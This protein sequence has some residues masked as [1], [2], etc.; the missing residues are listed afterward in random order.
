MKTERTQ[1]MIINKEDQY[2]N[3]KILVPDSQVYFEGNISNLVGHVF[4]KNSKKIPVEFNEDLFKKLKHA[5]QNSKNEKAIAL[6]Y[7]DLTKNK[8][9]KTEG[10]LEWQI[11]KEEKGTLKPAGCYIASNEPEN[12]YIKTAPRCGVNTKYVDPL[13]D[14]W[15]RQLR[16]PVIIV[17]DVL[18]QPDVKM[19]KKRHYQTNITS[20]QDGYPLKRQ[21]ID[22]LPYIFQCYLQKQNT[23]CI[24]YLNNLVK[25]LFDQSSPLKFAFYG[26]QF[27]FSVLMYFEHLQTKLTYDLKQCKTLAKQI[28]IYNKYYRKATLYDFNRFLQT[29]LMERIE[30]K[31]VENL[32][33]FWKIEINK[34]IDNPT[35]FAV[36]IMLTKD[37]EKNPLAQR[38]AQ[39]ITNMGNMS[40]QDTMFCQMSKQIN[41]FM[42]TQST[43]YQK[44]LIIDPYSFTMGKQITLKFMNLNANDVIAIS[45]DENT[46]KIKLNQDKIVMIPIEQFNSLSSL[47]IKPESQKGVKFNLDFIDPKY[48]L[49]KEVQLISTNLQC[50]TY[51]IDLYKSFKPL[52]LQV[53]GVFYRQYSNFI[54]DMMYQATANISYLYDCKKVK[55]PLKYVFELDEIQFDIDKLNL[56]NLPL[57]LS[58]G[59]GQDIQ[60][61]L[62]DYGEL[63]KHFNMSV[64]DANCFKIEMDNNK[65]D[66]TIVEKADDFKVIGGKYQQYWNMP[67]WSMYSFLMRSKKDVNKNDHFKESD[68]MSR[69]IE[70]LIRKAKQK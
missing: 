37:Y 15:T 40:L 58:A 56:D 20:D 42:L 14:A 55:R 5:G 18:T 16:Q 43:D 8:Y 21:F 30:T 61:T 49:P 57:Y 26:H 39:M 59:L 33:K 4:V 60:F 23:Q 46:V 31:N 24:D 1:K 44:P 29:A 32:T 6:T 41:T 64:I 50:N 45:D 36:F 34:K 22:F 53:S 51:K 68:R 67:Y 38:E 54:I 62:I 52:Y 35:M 28:T 69:T 63:S 9:G 65:D 25:T 7:A 70:E 3:R 48:S 10:L 19:L 27:I 13:I 12:T 11:P 47:T 66:Q 2:D 17:N